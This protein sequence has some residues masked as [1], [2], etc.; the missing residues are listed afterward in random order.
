MLTHIFGSR[1]DLKLL[2]EEA[3]KRDM[4]IILDVVLNHTGDVLPM[5]Q[6]VQSGQEKSI[7]SLLLEICMATM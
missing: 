3:H 6:E 4:R 5:N 1:E 7:M 2:V